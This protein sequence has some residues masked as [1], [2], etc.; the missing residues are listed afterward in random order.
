MRNIVLIISLAAVL[1]IAP[2][3]YGEGGFVNES[4]REIPVAH[5]VD[6]RRRGRQHGRRVGGS[7]GG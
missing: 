4:A 6:G 3:V 1:A 5:S 7:R 2:R